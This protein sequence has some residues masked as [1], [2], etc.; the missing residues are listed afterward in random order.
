MGFG[1]E[2]EAIARTKNGGE[3][4]RRFDFFHEA[5]KLAI[6]VDGPIHKKQRGR[7]RRRDT[8]FATDGI[9]TLRFSNKRALT[10]TEAVLDEIRSALRA[11]TNK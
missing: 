5:A 4:P 2:Y 10:E 11:T 8:R 1:L 6:E 9:A 7:D 3:Y